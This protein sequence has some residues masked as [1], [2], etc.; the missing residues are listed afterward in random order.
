MSKGLHKH[1]ARKEALQ[2][3]GRTLARR[4]RSSCELCGDSGVSLQAWEVTPLA[5]EP[6]LDRTLLLCQPCYRGV[7][8]EPLEPNRWRFLTEAIWSALPPAQVCAVRTLHRLAAMPGQA[9]AT[10]T[11]DTLY[12]DP[13]IEAWVKAS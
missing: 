4:A 7:A 13:E 11:L 6:E 8:G 3:L 12:L 9:W 1:Q 2:A 10:E 5:E